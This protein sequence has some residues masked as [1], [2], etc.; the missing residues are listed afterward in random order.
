M[1]DDARA[2]LHFLDELQQFQPLDENGWPVSVENEHLQNILF[3]L[4]H[5]RHFVRAIS[6]L[7][8]RRNDSL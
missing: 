8:K 2:A 4:S 6:I 5:N 1:L 7:N 3:K